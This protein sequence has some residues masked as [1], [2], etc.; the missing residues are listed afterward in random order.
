MHSRKNLEPKNKFLEVLWDTTATKEDKP[1]LKKKLP[2]QWRNS[3]NNSSNPGVNWMN[4]LQWSVYKGIKKKIRSCKPR[5]QHVSLQ[6]PC[7]RTCNMSPINRIFK[8]SKNKRLFCIC[9]IEWH[10]ETGNRVYGTTL[11]AKIAVPATPTEEA[12]VTAWCI[13]RRPEGSGLLIVLFILASLF[14]SNT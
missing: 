12:Q 7:H 1:T 3:T 11:H 4:L 2:K 10:E 6:Q 8:I 9:I 5:C 13:L 14:I